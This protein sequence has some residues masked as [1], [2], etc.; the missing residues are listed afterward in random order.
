MRPARLGVAD[1]LR[2][3]A[4]RLPRV[5]KE[6]EILRV[7][8]AL[9]G[10]DAS[11]VAAMARD[12]VLRWAQK[13]SG[14]LLPKDAWSHLSFE[15][16]AGGRNCSAVRIN[17]ESADIWAV[18]ADDPDKTVP[19]RVWTTEATVAFL[20]SR[21]AQFGLRLLVSSPE[22]ELQID[23]HVPGLVAQIV[24]RCGLVPD[25][26][27]IQVSPWL[28]DRDERANRLIEYLID[29]SR[30]I[31]I[32]VLSVAEN[33][34]D[35]FSPRLDAGVLAKACAGLARVAVL[36]ARFS[37]ALTEEFGKRLSVFGGAA[38]WYLPGFSAESDPY[39]GH[40]LILRES[41]EADPDGC[42]NRIRWL[43]AQESLRNNKLDEE[44]L[45][46]ASI[47]SASL[48]IQQQT[49]LE[50]DAS[51]TVR[52]DAALNR[53]EFLEAEA[54][55]W[56]EWEQTLSDEHS[57]AEE[58][59][60]VAEAQLQA[61]AYRIQQL[62]DQLKADGR[63]P[64]TSIETPVSWA[65]FADWC[66]TNLVGRVAL[67]P[68]ARRAVKN[69]EFD[70]PS[71]AARCLIWLA[72]RGRNWKL[73]GGVG[74]IGDAEVEPGYWNSHCGSDAFD[75]TL[76]GRD[77]VVDWRIKSGGNTRDPRRCLRI[78]YFWDDISRQFVIAEMPAH[79]VTSAS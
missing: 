31:P 64:D 48:R 17:T 19:G 51:E 72:N 5:I 53:I 41:I 38:R 54:E 67:T 15:Y 12:E 1:A 61:S 3:L 42:A 69:P 52:L 25:A 46:F 60:Q 68:K 62:Q 22:A 63:E 66:D 33:Q 27:P 13:R 70:D 34:E 32:I 59:A 20:G 76:Q 79:R 55:R 24:D 77:Y 6:H 78:Y 26:Y 35:E 28:V 23:P 30:K 71:L 14:G 47:K 50:Q 21:S 44:V 9:D 37:W 10:E 2:S 49:L 75:V 74:S 73:G 40:R 8:G 36:P 7:S 11:S 65:E 45:A 18:R 29:G 56:K 39:G 43:A 16:L 57:A 58:R 4:T